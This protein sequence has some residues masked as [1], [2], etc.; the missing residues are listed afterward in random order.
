MVFETTSTSRRIR[1]Q[2]FQ[3]PSAREAAAITLCATCPVRKECAEASVTPPPVVLTG[4]GITEELARQDVPPRFEV[5]GIWA[6]ARNFERKTV[7]QELGHGPD[8]V[9]AIL[10]IG[11]RLAR[12]Y[13][14]DPSVLWPVG[15]QPK[16]RKKSMPRAKGGSVER[17]GSGKPG[18]GRG[19]R[20]PVGLYVL[21]HGVSRSTAW[22]RLRAEAA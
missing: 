10:A 20:G 3:K 19:K 8:A 6:G 4:P 22:R 7:V 16:A 13:P 12:E 5:W 18:P 9:A 11:E 17:I 1:E 14:G 2:G 15:E 21:Q